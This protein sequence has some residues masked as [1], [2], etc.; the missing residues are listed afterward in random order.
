MLWIKNNLTFLVKAILKLMSDKQGDVPT[1][2][3]AETN[4]Y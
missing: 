4:C 1:Q 2:Q 3:Q